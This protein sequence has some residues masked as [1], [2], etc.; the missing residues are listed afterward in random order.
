V[1]EETDYGK[2]IGHMAEIRNDL[3]LLESILREENGRMVV[4]IDDLDRCEP[5]KAV[6]M[7]Q[8]INL[9]LNFESF[10]VVMGIDA[11][12]VTRAIE[13]HYRDL[14]GPAG[15][16]GYEY[17]DKIVKIPFRIPESEP[18]TNKDLLPRLAIADVPRGA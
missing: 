6:E 3:E 15:A 11:R 7:L 12:I 4:V 1:V 2:Q 18:T 13:K 14:L 17:L 9:L 5:E 10:I 16:S 8:A